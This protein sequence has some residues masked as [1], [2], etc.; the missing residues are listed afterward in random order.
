MTIGL[1]YPGFD[2]T[3][4]AVIGGALGVCLGFGLQNIISFFPAPSSSLKMIIKVDDIVDL[5]SVVMGKVTGINL[6]YTRITTTD[7]IDIIVPDSEFITGRVVN[8]TLGER[9]D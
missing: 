6:R 1:G 5:Q 3:S 2:V 9:G 4:F 7:L 8:W